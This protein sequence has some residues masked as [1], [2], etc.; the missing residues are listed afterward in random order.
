MGEWIIG[1][2]IGSYQI[3]LIEVFRKNNKLSIH[4]FSLIKVPVGCIENGCIKEIEILRTLLAQ[5]LKQKAYRGKKVVVV[6]GSGEM[7]IRDIKLG[8]V[9]QRMIKM[10]LQKQIVQYLPLGK[11]AYQISYKRLNIIKQEEDIQEVRVVAMPK[12]NVQA[13]LELVKGLKKELV[14]ITIPSEALEFVFGKKGYIT[15]DQDENIMTVEIG[16]EAT[17][18]TIISKGKVVLTRQIDFGALHVS[19]SVQEEALDETVASQINTHIIMEMERLLQ[20]YKS[21]FSQAPL[22]MI[23]LLGGG[24]TLKGMRTSIHNV[25]KV[26]TEKISILSKVEEAPHIIFGPYKH[27]F[28]NLLGAINGYD[29]QSIRRKWQIDLVPEQYSYEQKYKRWHRLI[30]AVGIVESVG[31]ILGFVVQPS[32]KYQH[33]QIQLKQIQEKLAR[34]KYEAI[35]DVMNHLQVAESDLEKWKKQ[36]ESLRQSDL[37]NERNLDSMINRVP[38]GVSID[39]LSLDNEEAAYRLEIEG[40]AVDYEGIYQYVTILGETY[41]RDNVKFAMDDMVEKDEKLLH[42]TVQIGTKANKKLNESEAWEEALTLEDED[43]NDEELNEIEQ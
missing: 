2:E 18:M 26:P 20:F 10:A 13:V 38:Y 28:I 23:Y 6:M 16:H 43:L 30:V 39:S 32:I 35:K 14:F 31:F 29:K 9:T 33:Q 12:Q 22:K 8:K 24:S 15:Y 3:K 25:F 36:Y 42:Y 40:K 7:I 4:Q 17:S 11:A 19:L 37:I 21:N 1:I 5:E 41:G 34:P 27:F